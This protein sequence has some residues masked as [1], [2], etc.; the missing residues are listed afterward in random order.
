[1]VAAAKLRRQAVHDFKRGA[2]LDAARRV[3][4]ARG[5][6]GATVRA[7]AGEAG[8]SPGAIYA[9]YPAKEEIYGE[10]L[11]ESLAQ[12]GQAVKRAAAEAGG[13]EQRLRRSV[14]AYYDYYREHPHEFELGLHLFRAAHRASLS[15]ECARLI[16]GRLIAALRLV[17]EA[18]AEMGTPTPEAANRETVAL[19]AHVSG[20]LELEA[21][22]R[23]EVLGFSGRDL[24]EHYLD[25][26]ASRLGASK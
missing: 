6:D 17:A 14:G 9:Y 1:M 11:A 5:L 22:G 21:G 23:L 12:A 13:P 16:T 25:G 2:I 24:L 3:F 26:V 4:A 20:I 19:L 18:L 10:M 15:D 8:Y 7:I